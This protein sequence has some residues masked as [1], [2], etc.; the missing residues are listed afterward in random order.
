[1]TDKEVMERFD[2]VEWSWRAKQ[3]VGREIGLDKLGED[4]LERT[5]EM[6]GGKV[7]RPPADLRK[8]PWTS[9]SAGRGR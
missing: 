8:A 3:K 7:V 5:A 2:A 6:F 9:A 1:M 4:D